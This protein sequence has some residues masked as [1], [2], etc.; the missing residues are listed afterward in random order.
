MSVLKLFDRRFRNTGNGTPSNPK[1]ASDDQRDRSPI[2][3]SQGREVD[4]ANDEAIQTRHGTGGNKIEKH[5]PKDR[6]WIA[7][8][9]DSQ[10][11]GKPGRS[12]IENERGSEDMR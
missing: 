2:Q 5:N 8:A 3:V 11:R 9:P 10:A 1:E 4:S 12:R 7:Y 6:N